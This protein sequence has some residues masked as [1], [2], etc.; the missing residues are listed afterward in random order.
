[1]PGGAVGQLEAMRGITGALTNKGNSDVEDYYTGHLS[2][3]IDDD[4]RGI[5]SRLCSA[6]KN[7][8]WSLTR[9]ACA[10]RLTL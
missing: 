1:M 8:S 4:L 9:T 5:P 10:L 2:G 7:I 6:G 3:F